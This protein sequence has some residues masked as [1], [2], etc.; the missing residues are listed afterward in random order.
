MINTNNNYVINE[1]DVEMVEIL[2]EIAQFKKEVKDDI[3]G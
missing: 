3:R 1:I 2:F